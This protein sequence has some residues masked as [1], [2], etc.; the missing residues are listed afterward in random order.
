MGAWLF[1]FA[2]HFPVMVFHKGD[3]SRWEQYEP[4]VVDMAE[5][6]ARREWPELD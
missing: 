1:V 6:S 4:V 2:E 3:L 5:G